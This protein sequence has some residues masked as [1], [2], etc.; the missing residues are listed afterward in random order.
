[1]DIGRPNSATIRRRVKITFRRLQ[2]DHSPA[3]DT[4]GRIGRKSLWRSAKTRFEACSISA[5]RGDLRQRHSG[6]LNREREN[7]A[8]YRS[9]C[10]G[11]STSGRKLGIKKSF[12]S[13]VV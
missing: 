3:A 7:G 6:Y 11:T 10:L 9:K 5:G 12:G 1:L 2:V 4:M 13:R 8:R